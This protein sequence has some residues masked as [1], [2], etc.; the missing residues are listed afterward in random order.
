MMLG[1]PQRGTLAQ[2]DKP[3]SKELQSLPLNTVTHLNAY[4]SDP[5]VSFPLYSFLISQW[6]FCLQQDIFFKILMSVNFRWI[7]VILI[8]NIQKT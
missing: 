1:W 3:D 8:L 5:D 7:H 2:K 4:T 6:T